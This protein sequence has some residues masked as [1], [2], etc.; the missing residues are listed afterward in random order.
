MAV[1]AECAPEYMPAYH[2]FDAERFVLAM[3]N[4]DRWTVWRTA[5]NRGEIHRGA[6]D[7]MGRYVARLSFY[8]SLFWV[9]QQELKRRMAEATNPE[10]C[11]ITEDLVFTEPYIDHEHNR[12]APGVEPAVRELQRDQR[13][14]AEVGKLKFQFM[15]AGE[16]LVHGDLHTGSV[17]VALEGGRGR[18]RAFDSEFCYYGPVGFDLGALFGN[19]LFAQVRA[20]ALGRPA[21]FTRWVAGLPS[22][23]WRAFEDEMRSL[24]PKRRETFLNDLYFEHWLARI[25]QDAAGFG[26]CKAIRRIIGFAKVS[27][28]QTL[29]AD[30]H[31]AAATA[32]LRAASRWI[33]ERS[34]VERPEDL[35]EI[36]AAAIG[37]E[38]G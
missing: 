28:I 9:E 32:V 31:V 1:T 21:D 29:E 19:Y 37:K 6:E 16:A 24:W 25:L 8:T 2:G 30:A 34:A 11:K 33:K 26:G 13:H 5:L 15:T 4:M 38:I 14:V 3:E 35:E 10:L 22:G 20:A 36:A 17:F 7:D 27:D 23:T 12:W 18:G